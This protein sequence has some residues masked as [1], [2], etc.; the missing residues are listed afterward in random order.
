MKAGDFSDVVE[1]ACEFTGMHNVPT[2]NRTK[3]LSDNGS[4]LVG[5]DFGDYLEARGIGHIFASLYHS[6][7]NGKIERYH[8]SMKEQV[9][10]HVWEL[11]EEL[12]KKITMFVNWYN[13]RRY[14]EA[15]GNVTPDDVYYDRREKIV[16]KRKQLKSKTTLERKRINCKIIGIGAEI[17]S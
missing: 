3:L 11:P 17:A 4:A 16:E 15:I 7:T 13:S 9:F 8:R 14:H 2:N 12:E 10:L 6:Q 5:K 1:L